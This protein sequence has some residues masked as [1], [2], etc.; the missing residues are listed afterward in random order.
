MFFQKNQ[1]MNYSM[2]NLSSMKT[3]HNAIDIK[4]LK[5]GNPY[6]EMNKDNDQEKTTLIQKLMKKFTKLK[7]NGG[8]AKIKEIIDEKEL[9]K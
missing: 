5:N 9:K 4:S 7:E 1:G 6:H 8:L 3:W 2:S